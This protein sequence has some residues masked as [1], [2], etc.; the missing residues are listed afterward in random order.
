MTLGTRSKT[1]LYDPL[2]EAFKRSEFPFYWVAQ[3][4]SLYTKRM[5]QLLKR[6]GMDIP[7]W[8]IILILREHSELS[9][10]EIAGHAVAK[11]PTTTKIVYRMRDEGLV[12][13]STSTEDGRVTL[14][15]LTEKGFDILL[16]T[17]ES[18]STFFRNSFKE[19]SSAEIHR[20]NTLLRKLYDN[21]NDQL[22]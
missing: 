1:N 19:M 22:R 4:N 14:V 16:L 18:V 8:R 20:T 6:V 17:Q 13:L 7:R 21:L 15:S 12:N 11:L 10:S 5:E 3:L 9:M 2:S